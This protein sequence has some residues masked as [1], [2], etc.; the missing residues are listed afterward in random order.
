[1]TTAGIA[2]AAAAAALAIVVL[3]TVSVARG[4]RASELRMTRAL[5]DL[6]ARMEMLGHDLGEAIAHVQT[7][8]RRQRVI[9]ELG[10]SIDLGEVLARTVEA[11]SLMPGVDASLVRASSHEGSAT[12]AVVGLPEDAPQR[13]AI[14][15]PP[16]GSP[17]RA[18]SVAYLYSSAHADVAPIRSGLAVPLLGE[19][20]EPLGFLSVYGRGADQLNERTL[21]DLELLAL[22][23][24][25][26]IDNARRYGEARQLADTDALT[27]LHNRRT[28][29]ETLGREVA[30]AQRYGR[31]L[32]LIVLDL[33]DFKEVN[34]TYGHLA[35]DAVLAE[36]GDRLRGV[37]RTADVAC[38]IG[39][40]EFAVIL[41]ESG[42][43][44]AEALYHRLA[45]AISNRPVTEVGA[46]HFSAGIGE[47]RPDDDAVSLFE[48]ADRS[49]YAAKH[50][51]KNR[52]IADG[53]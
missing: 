53:A 1:M 16:D 36:V 23:A 41:P 31:D 49:L 48:R 39:G 8:N 38:R 24:A 44:E 17:V 27:G 28:F 42:L 52:A 4:R 21:G 10:T 18:V 6:G 11:A 26:A 7:E 30:R 14:S 51:G 22:R 20:D 35:G 33:D 5:A 25:P 19:E 32:A 9:S 43:A 46:V 15:G 13:Y 12:T 29:H 2:L 50:G 47:L 3:A 40:E 45:T 37:A 34:D